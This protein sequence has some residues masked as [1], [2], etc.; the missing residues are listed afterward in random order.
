MNTQTFDS[1][2]LLERV[3]LP[4]GNIANVLTSLLDSDEDL[5]L[6]QL[7]RGLHVVR[8]NAEDVHL[9]LH[10]LAQTTV[11]R[12]EPKTPSQLRHWAMMGGALHEE[13]SSTVMLP[14]KQLSEIY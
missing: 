12:N 5:N 3:T 2:D 7:R 11:E 9:F 10:G 13:E 1:E 6:E 14:L 8:C 4:I